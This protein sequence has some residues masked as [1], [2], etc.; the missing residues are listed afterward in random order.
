MDRKLIDY[1][2]PVLQNIRELR[3]INKAVEPELS[4]AWDAYALLL[5]NLFLDSATELGVGIWEQE[6]KL[7]PKNT[8]SLDVRKARIKAKWN[9][10]VPYSIPWL[11]SWLAG[12]CGKIG[13]E[14]SIS[15]YTIDVQLDYD[16]LPNAESLTA[17]ILDMLLAIRPAN[18]QIMM[19]AFLQSYSNAVV[20]AG[21]SE[22]ST[23]VE[24][25]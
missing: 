14:V 3:E 11:K 15:D 21:V 5:A 17:E 25:F 19:T 18:M 23:V 10:D 9:L 2:P 4:L 1:L 13:Y 16:A 6:L 7:L 12:L 22:C 8:D 24:I 20:F